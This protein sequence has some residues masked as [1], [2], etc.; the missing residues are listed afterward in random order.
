MEVVEF[1]GF[2]VDVCGIGGTARR[3]GGLPGL[4]NT[5]GLEMGGKVALGRVEGPG[6]V[7]VGQAHD[8]VGVGI[9][10]GEYGRATGA[11][12]RGRTETVAKPDAFGGEAVEARGAYRSYA[13]T[14]EKAAHIVADHNEDVG[15]VFHK[16]NI[17]EAGS[18]GQDNGVCAAIFILKF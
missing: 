4:G 16:E 10:A 5:S 3:A 11:V 9:A 7:A 15:R 6:E 18:K 14:P 12:L 17:A 1:D 2:K 8:A 13:V